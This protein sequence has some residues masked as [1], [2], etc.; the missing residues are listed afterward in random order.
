GQKGRERFAQTLFNLFMLRSLALLCM[1]VWD[2]E[3]D[4]AWTRLSQAQALLD[5]VWHSA[6]ADQPR[7]VRDVRW[8]FPVAMS[9]TTDSLEGYF[10][11]AAQIAERFAEADGIETQ[12]AWVQTGAGHLRSQLYH[13]AVRRNVDLADHSLV[14]I[15]RMSNAL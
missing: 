11:V 7:L 15:T 1:R 10:P 8:L 12:R 9:P 5:A 2:A 4:T 3:D 6:A 13:L 14:L